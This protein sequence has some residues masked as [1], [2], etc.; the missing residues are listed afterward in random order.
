MRRAGCATRSRA[1]AVFTS[2]GHCLGTLKW[3]MGDQDKFDARTGAVIHYHEVGT[4]HVT[5]LLILPRAE[6]TRLSTSAATSQRAGDSPRQR[7]RA[8][9]T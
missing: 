8:C 2:D 6:R 7:V 1:V 4:L 9:A 3:R 5:K